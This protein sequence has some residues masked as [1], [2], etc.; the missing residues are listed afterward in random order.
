MKILAS[1]V[2]L[3]V[4]AYALAQIFFPQAISFVGC[5]VGR[6]NSCEDY[7]AYL[8][9]ERDYEAAKKPFEKACEA[10]LGHSCAIAADLY[11]DDANIYKTTK[12]LNKATR[13]YSKAC[14]LGSR[15]AC[16]NTAIIFY[17]NE[18][19]ENAF[20]FFAKSCDLGV[21]EGCLEAGIASYERKDYEGALRFFIKSCDAGLADGCERVGLAYS[22]KEF[23][24]P[25]L[26]R[27]MIYYDKACKIGAEF[28]CNV[29][30]AMNK[31][32]ETNATK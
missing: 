1:I 11:Y 6:A 14:E 13:L 15:K 30:A 12:N 3:L 31:I 10:G 5:S 8:L 32:N 9:E 23:G 17:R 27:A 16:Y 19:K 26:N 2:V 18:D 28:S 24:E 4:G 25:D 29:V 7:G 20:L 21:G 22:K